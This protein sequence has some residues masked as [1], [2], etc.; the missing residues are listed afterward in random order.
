[1]QQECCVFYCIQGGKKLDGSEA[2]SIISL[3]QREDIKLAIRKGIQKRMSEALDNL[4]SKLLDTYITRAFYDPADFISD[5][6]EPYA[7]SE[8]RPELR[9]VVDGVEKK[10]FGKDADAFTITLKLANRDTALKT[11]SDFMSNV[12]PKAEVQVTS[13]VADNTEDEIQRLAEMSYDELQ[14]ELQK[15]QA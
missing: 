3:M 5:D 11:L 13:A 12:R 7:L 14:A 4:D 15:A 9:C 10:Y 6:G 1:M 2:P 8:I